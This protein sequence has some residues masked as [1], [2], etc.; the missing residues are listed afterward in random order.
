MRTERPTH[1][2]RKL[3]ALLGLGTCVIALLTYEMCIST[4]V[5]SAPGQ[6]AQVMAAGSRLP[7]ITALRVER[8][9]NARVVL[10]GTNGNKDS[11]AVD[12]KKLADMVAVM[13]RLTVIK[14]FCAWRQ[15]FTLS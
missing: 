6:T 14:P 9:R 1:E 2:Y 10:Q 7:E 3:G 5:G 4:Q 11:T 8:Q 13:K 15:S 12:R